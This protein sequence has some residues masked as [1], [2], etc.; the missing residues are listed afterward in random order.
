M[1]KIF[2]SGI[3]EAVTDVIPEEILK[4]YNLPSFR[5]AIVWIHEPQNKDDALSARK[6]FAFEEIF[7][8]QLDRQKERAER[9]RD[10]RSKSKER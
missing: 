2:G 5:T 8:I 6:R 1:R 10:P 4:K 9:A 3:L 7:F